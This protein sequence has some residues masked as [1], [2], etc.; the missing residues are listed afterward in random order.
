VLGTWEFGRFFFIDGDLAYI[1]GWSV[2]DALYPVGSAIV[3]MLA[4]RF[5]KDVVVP[6]LRFT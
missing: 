1:I 2:V 6:R 5:V 3:L 4:A